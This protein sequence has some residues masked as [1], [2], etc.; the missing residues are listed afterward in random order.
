MLLL[1][2][3]RGNGRIGCHAMVLGGFLDILLDVN[4]LVSDRWVNDLYL[5]NTN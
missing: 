3:V 5:S 1:E 2:L 4:P